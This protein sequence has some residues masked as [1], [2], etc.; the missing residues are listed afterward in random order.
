MRNRGHQS[1]TST[2][3]TTNTEADKKRLAE[4]V[5]GKA[6]EKTDSQ[7]EMKEIAHAEIMLRLT[8]EA[9]K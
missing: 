9:A 4:I 8:N 3:T 6:F 7:R 1:S 2:S 5:A